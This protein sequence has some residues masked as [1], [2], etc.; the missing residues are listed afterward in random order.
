[1]LVDAAQAIDMYRL[2]GDVVKYVTVYRYTDYPEV[3]LLPIAFERV[4][5]ESGVSI[6]RVERGDTDTLHVFRFKHRGIEWK[7][8]IQRSEVE[9]FHL[10]TREQPRLPEPSVRIN[11]KSQLL[12][13]SST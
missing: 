2:R 5:R 10:L 7:C 8:V 4:F 9:E 3:C 11:A 6:K 12:L 13:G 1:M